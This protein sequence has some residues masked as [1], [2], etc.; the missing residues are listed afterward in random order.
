VINLL[1]K[2]FLCLFVIFVAV[3]LLTSCSLGFELKNQLGKNLEIINQKASPFLTF[4]KT[5]KELQEKEKIIVKNQGVLFESFE[6]IDGWTG[7]QGNSS[8]ESDNLYKKDGAYGLKLI[9]LNGY[10]SSSVGKVNYDF[11]SAKNI[12]F[13][14]YAHNLENLESISIYFSSTDDWSKYFYKKIENA[15]FKEGWN[16]FLVAKSEFHSI[17]KED[18]GNIIINMQL[19]C[20]PI[21]GKST[22]VTFDDFRY[23]YQAKPTVVICFDDSFESVFT[24]AYPI[25]AS[26]QQQA[27]VFVITSRVGNQG[28]MSKIELKT[29]KLDGWDICNHSVS[30]KDLTTLKEP[31]VNKE[32][33]ESYDWLVDNGF[34]E[35][36]CF[37]AYPFGKYNDKVVDK[38]KEKNKLA[39]STIN[40]LFQPNIQIG[41]DEDIQYLL[42]VKNITNKTILQDVLGEIDNNIERNGFLFLL[43]HALSETKTNEETRYQTADFQRISNYLRE[44]E[45]ENKLEVITLSEYYEI[46][47]K[48]E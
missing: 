41:D 6:N 8:Q 22:N 13:W 32:I 3:S 2:L 19:T 9:S 37:F 43:F 47:S 18:W 36:A 23:D 21:P 31:E 17:G 46:I 34:K 15:N 38:V 5:I 4:Q 10:K 48:T 39:H 40:G 25:L 45:D 20:E 24:D 1:R 42:K 29:L 35:T 26:N 27:S 14:V 28:Y 12:I 7:G 44:K 33:N 16:R 11:S 30:H